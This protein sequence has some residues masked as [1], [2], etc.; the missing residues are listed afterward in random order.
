DPAPLTPTGTRRY[1]AGDSAGHRHYLAAGIISYDRQPG[2]YGLYV[3]THPQLAWNAGA[4]LIR[5]ALR[6]T[7]VWTH[8]L[9]GARRIDTA[10]PHTAVGGRLGLLQVSPARTSRARFHCGAALLAAAGGA[11]VGPVEGDSSAWI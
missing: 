10:L 6:L 2:T 8:A 5:S 1:H 7:A 3:P 11:H 4:F 9:S